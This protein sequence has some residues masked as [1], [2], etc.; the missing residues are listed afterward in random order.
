[1][2]WVRLY[3]G[4]DIAEAHLVRDWLVDRG[5]TVQLRG[6]HLAS[7]AGMIPSYDACPSVWVPKAEED[8]G[9]AAMSDFD[10]ASNAPDAAPWVCPG[11][12]SEN[13]GHFGSCWKCSA[14]RPGLQTQGA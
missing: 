12:M 5:L 6:E 4:F 1:M 10:A 9:L 3:R 7:T 13:D 8:A 2:R 14:D 11:C